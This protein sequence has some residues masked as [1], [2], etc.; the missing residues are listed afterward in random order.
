LLKL[1]ITRALF[2][3][4]VENILFIKII[5]NLMLT[6]EK[7]YNFAI[8]IF[9]TSLSFFYIY[10][11]LLKFNLTILDFNLED[12]DCKNLVNFD[13]AISNI[14]VNDKSRFFFYNALMLIKLNFNN[15]FIKY[16]LKNCAILFDQ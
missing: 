13:F 9:D 11:I 15:F 4:F 5:S 8:A 10:I 1:L 12:F 2:N 7:T 14:L 3:A 6:F 16:F